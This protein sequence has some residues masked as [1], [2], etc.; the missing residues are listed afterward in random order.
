MLVLRKLLFLASNKLARRYLFIKP[1]FEPGLEPGLELELEPGLDSGY[2]TK[3][4][5]GDF[6]G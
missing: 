1:G 2:E 4:T 6:D 3:M 5:S